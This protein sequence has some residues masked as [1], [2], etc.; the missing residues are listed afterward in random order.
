MMPDVAERFDTGQWEFTAEV[1]AVFD[2]HV[3]ASV[4]FYDAIQDLVAATTDWLLPAG[5]LVADLGASTGTTVEAILRRHPARAV[6]AELYDEQPDMLAQATVRLEAEVAAGRVRMHTQRVQDGPL[7]HEEANLTLALFLLQFLTPAD[8]VTALTA[9][10]KA[11][12]A[13]GAL[14]VAEKVRVGDPRWAEI[15]IDVSHDWKAEHGIDPAAIRAKAR[16]LRGVLVPRTVEHN[17]GDF[18]AAGWQTPEVLFRWHQWVVFGS[19]A[20]P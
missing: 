6:R 4:P 5:S 9:A 8:R 17:G 3:R 12:A 15:A 2:E 11:S 7:K 18:A 19:F 14:I 13:D 20:A 1:A 10:R 16:A